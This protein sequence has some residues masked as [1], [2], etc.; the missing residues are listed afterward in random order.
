MNKT[1]LGTLVLIATFSG[2]SHAQ[3]ML[4]GQSVY[5]R[6]SAPDSS[7]RVV[8][9]AAAKPINVT[10]GDTV[11]FVNGAQRF[12]W[13]FDVASHR[14]VPIASVAPAGFGTVEQVVYV[15]RHAGERG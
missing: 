14:A 10:C 6:A 5:G 11:T 8:D 4:N 9:L 2:A 15:S 3:T 1:M 12:T 7:T 13:K